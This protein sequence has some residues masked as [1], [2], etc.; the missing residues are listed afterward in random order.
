MALRSRVLKAPTGLIFP[1]PVLHQRY[2]LE[3]AIGRGGYARVY[4]ARE[5]RQGTL[6]AVKRAHFGHQSPDVLAHEAEML[7]R[8]HHPAIP[9]FLEYFEEDG[10]CYL[11]EAWHVGT[12]M[13]KQRF[14]S[15]PHLLW[16]GRRCTE[17]LAFLHQQGIVHRDLKPGNV[18]LEADRLSLLDFGLACAIERAD[19]AG[20]ASPRLLLPSPLLTSGSPGYSA[21]EQWEGV[22]SLA[23][24]IYS[25]GMLLGCALTDRQPE[26]IERLHSFSGLWGNPA[27]LPG[28]KLPFLRLLDQM[29]APAPDD[30]PGLPEVQR[31]LA[32]LERQLI[33]PC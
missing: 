2:T 21:P 23:N 11:V 17:V 5:S 29:I 26:E 10:W 28:E 33:V 3:Q 24:D 12:P 7:A 14:F 32:R 13:S 25:L 6:V 15:L 19:G 31:T 22:V 30:R 16:I 27:H 1:P 9:A 18:L 8:L 20:Q 4:R